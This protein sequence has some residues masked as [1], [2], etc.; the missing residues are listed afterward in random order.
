MTVTQHDVAPGYHLLRDGDAW[1]A[2]GPEFVDFQRSPAGFGNTQEAAVRELRAELRNAGY[3]DHSL[4]WDQRVQGPPTNDPRRCP[5]LA[6]DQAGLEGCGPGVQARA[7]S[8]PVSTIPLGTPPT[9]PS[10]RCCR[11]CQRSK[12]R[13]RSPTPS[14]TRSRSTPNGS[15]AAC[16]ASVEPRARGADSCQPATWPIGNR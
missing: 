4:P 5:C 9:P 16:T 6:R 1:C 8:H 7:E 12:P 11:R 14:P 15:G 10:A 2:V 3:P 13:G